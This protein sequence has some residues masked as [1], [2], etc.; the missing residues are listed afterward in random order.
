MT[1]KNTFFFQMWILFAVFVLFL[2]ALKIVIK[3]NN[4]KEGYTPPGDPSSPIYSHSVDLPISSP[5]TCSNFCGPQAQCAKTREQCT[6]DVDCYGCQ[7][8]YVKPNV[9]GHNVKGN[10]DAGKLT[11][12]QAPQYSV[13]TSD[14]GTKAAWVSPTSKKNKIPQ[15]DLGYDTWTKSFNTGMELFNKKEKANNKYLHINMEN[16]PKWN[17]T[18]GI[19]GTFDITGPNPAN[20]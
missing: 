13:L 14:I 20:A 17:T 11:F 15:M 12:N 9:E 4:N 5:Y 19:M 16:A 18:E 8:T 3:S 10:D 2:F 1:S 7:P 6:S